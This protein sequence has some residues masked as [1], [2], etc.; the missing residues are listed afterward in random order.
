MDIGKPSPVT[1]D[2]HEPISTKSGLGDSHQSNTLDDTHKIDR[3][4]T[5]KTVM[6]NY[7]ALQKANNHRNK[8]RAGTKNLTNA[9]ALRKSTDLNQDV[10]RKMSI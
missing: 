3:A 1:V 10:N 4:D 8:R 7:I 2:T 6:D 9:I 5:M